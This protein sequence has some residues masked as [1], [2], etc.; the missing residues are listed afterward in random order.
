MLH[1]EVRVSGFLALRRLVIGTV[2]VAGVSSVPVAA[3]G[4]YLKLHAEQP[5]VQAAEP[6]KFRLT[7]TATR[8]VE[9]PTGPVLLVDDGGGMQPRGEAR[10]G[11]SVSR[12][13]PERPWTGSCEV[14]LE[15]PGSYQVR[16]RYRL[17]DRVVET[18]KVSVKVLD[19]S[20]KA[21]LK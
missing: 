17:A 5:E 7:A 18:N 4:L 20:Q 13:T 10:C 9:L 1:K 11:S 3:D 21:A 19:G 16:L 2:L 12:V 15:K 14:S 8:T 6:V